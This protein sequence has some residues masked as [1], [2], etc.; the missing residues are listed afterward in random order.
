LEQ[1]KS[2]DRAMNMALRL[3][4]VRARS[5]KEVRTRLADRGVD[6]PVLEKVIEKLLDLNY[7]D[8]AEFAGEWCRHLAFNL[9]YGNRR[10]EASLRE[11]GIPEEIITKAISENREELDEKA[12]LSRVLNKKIKGLETRNLDRKQKARL[13]RMLAG[14][15][16][17]TSLIYEALRNQRE[18][19]E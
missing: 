15:G 12:A 17:S 5:I 16:F 10:I 19:N 11:K 9:L 4:A 2:N 18:D 1:D 13:A 7:L 3:L 8:D 14:R 6:V